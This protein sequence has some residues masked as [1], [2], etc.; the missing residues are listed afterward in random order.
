MEDLQYYKFIDMP[1]TDLQHIKDYVLFDIVSSSDKPII[2]HTLN[3]SNFKIK[4]L[5]KSLLMATLA[6]CNLEKC[7]AKSVILFGVPPNS[8]VNIHIDGYTADRKGSSDFALNIPIQ[9]CEQ[10]VMHWY[11]GSYTLEEG[12]TSEKLKH[13]KIVWN[14][15]PELAVSKI[16]D[17]PCIVRVNTPHNVEN[18]S[19][20]YRLILS[21]RFTPDLAIQ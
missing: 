1:A 14:G 13:L 4:L 11:K 16:I 20:Q 7:E 21:I 17:S 2:S 18:L 10:G 5:I 12:M 3:L 15:E 9:N 6:Q 8:K 19:D